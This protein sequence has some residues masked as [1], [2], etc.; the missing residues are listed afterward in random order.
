MLRPDPPATVVAALIFSGCTCAGRL[1]GMTAVRPAEFAGSMY[2][3]DAHELTRQLDALLAQAQPFEGPVQAVLVPHAGMEWAGPVVAKALGALKGHRYKRI[4]VLAEAHKPKWSGVA[5]PAEA[6][7]ATPLG[8][9]P[10]D[11]AGIQLLEG[12]PPF[13]RKAVA[14][15]DDYVVEAL[16]PYLQRLWP[17]VPVLPVVV[18]RTEEGE[19]PR[20]GRTLRHVLDESTLLVA[21]ATFTHFGNWGDGQPFSLDGGK[22]ALEKRVYAYE[23]PVVDALLARAS[24]D[25]ARERTSHQAQTRSCGFNALSVLLGALDGGEKGTL[26]SRGTSMDRLFDPTDVSGVSYVGALFPG[27]WPAVA[28][29]DDE[30]RRTLGR[31]AEEGVQAAVH[32]RPAPELGELSPRLRQPGGAFVT[33][34]ENDRLRGC[35][36]RLAADTVAEAVATAARMAAQGDPRFN[37][38]RPDD[39]ARIELEISVM[40]PF[41]PLQSPTDFEPGRHGLLLT[42][43][44]RRGLLLPQVATKYALGRLEFLEA[45]ADKAGAPSGGWKDAKL[46]RFGVDA[47]EPKPV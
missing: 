21:T 8:N 15:D 35:M 32:G 2:P 9:V 33:L 34:T 11:A 41:E 47:F 5:L 25:W 24:E 27:R 36:G 19:R 29:L 45:L 1:P 39:L 40:G 12:Y 17:N 44:I 38:L 10:M 28:A 22:E 3:R 14:F 23:Q 37:P 20:L 18:G 43:G 42:Y 46:E 16:L 13:E 31:I 4:V 30:D 6:S 7:F 26:V